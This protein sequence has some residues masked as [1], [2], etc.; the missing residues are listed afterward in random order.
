[1][2]IFQNKIQ[3]EQCQKYTSFKGSQVH[4]FN[5]YIL[6]SGA[7]IKWKTSQNIQPTLTQQNIQWLPNLQIGLTITS[8]S[9]THSGDDKQF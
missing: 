5:E 8:T 3:V 4:E 2:W 6:Q 9:H 1:M 7:I